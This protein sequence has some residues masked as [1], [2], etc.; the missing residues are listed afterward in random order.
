MRH[1]LLLSLLSALLGTLLFSSCDSGWD[2]DTE[3]KSTVPY[4]KIKG[5]V[6]G[7]SVDTK[8]KY[9]D[10]GLIINPISKNN[11]LQEIWCSVNSV[12]Y[13]DTTGTFAIDFNI[14]DVRRGYNEF[15]DSTAAQSSG[16]T[17]CHFWLSEHG[18]MY[19]PYYEMFIKHINPPAFV[20][21]DV[22]PKW[23]ENSM[24]DDKGNKIPYF[25]ITGFLKGTFLQEYIP[26]YKSDTLR[27]DLDI[28]MV[29]PGSSYI[30]D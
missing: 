20:I 4:M 15:S 2:D 27:V 10:G 5:T 13:Q 29:T 18:R 12:G 7:K 28:E 14:A 11:W 19:R 26:S 22:Q 3:K 23:D 30:K 24:V 25:Y 8:I 6:N 1:I 9:Y 21:T 17:F 16:S